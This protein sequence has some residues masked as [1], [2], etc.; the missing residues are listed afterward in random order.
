MHRWGRREKR[1]DTSN[2]MFLT[3]SIRI[4]FPLSSLLQKPHQPWSERKSSRLTLGGWDNMLHTNCH[5]AKSVWW[6]SPLAFSTMTSSVFVAFMSTSFSTWLGSWVIWTQFK[7][8]THFEGSPWKELGGWLWMSSRDVSGFRFSLL[9]YLPSWIRPLYSL[10][11]WPSIFPPS[12]P[13]FAPLHTD[14]MHQSVNYYCRTCSFQIVLGAFNSVHE[15]YNYEARHFLRSTT[16]NDQMWENR[17]C[18]STG[19][20]Y[21]SSKTSYQSNQATIDGH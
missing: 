18:K 19:L 7:A 5:Y 2:A 17:G 8:S 20:G 13:R 10:N 12:S 4:W 14:D 21:D 15:L 3:P 11:R 16:K 6:Q 1:K 9:W